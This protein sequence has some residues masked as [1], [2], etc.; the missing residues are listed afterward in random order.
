MSYLVDE[1]NGLELIGE[2]D[3]PNLSYR[4]NTME[5]VRH[6]STGRVFYAVSWGCSCPVPFE[7]EHF[8]GPDDTS[9]TPITIGDS[10]SSYQRQLEEFP[11]DIQDRQE[12]LYAVRKAIG[13]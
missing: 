10:F 5:V 1:D 11:D 6:V 2:L 3:E 13:L 4:F 12:L 9:L 8:N 7:D